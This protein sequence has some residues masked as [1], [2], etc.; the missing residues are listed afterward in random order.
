MTR[1]EHKNRSN[2]SFPGRSFLHR[3]PELSGRETATMGRLI[4]FLRENTHLELTERDS[5]S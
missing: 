3:H 5:C 4:R 1:N 2:R